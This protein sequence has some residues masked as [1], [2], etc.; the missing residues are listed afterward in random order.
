VFAP[1]ISTADDATQLRLYEYRAV[2]LVNPGD[3]PAAFL[4]RLTGYVASGGGV[5]IALGDRTQAAA[6]NAAMHSGGLGFCPLAL[7]EPQGNASD[8]EQFVL[9]SPPST[10]SRPT[11]LLGDTQRLD[12][13][14]VRLYR[15]FAFGRNLPSQSV[16]LLL[17]TEHG[18][19][20]AF[21]DFSGNGRVIWLG[22]P[23]DLSWSNLPLCKSF[24]ALVREWLWYLAEPAT[25]QRNLMPGMPIRIPLERVA[26]VP[27]RKADLASEEEAVSQE[28]TVELPGGESLAMYE[29]DPS[30]APGLIF[31]GTQEPGRYLVSESPG[32]S[33]PD[34]SAPSPFFVQRDA[35]ESNLEAITQAQRD[36][37]ANAGGLRYGSASWLELRAHRSHSVAQ[38]IASYLLFA[39]LLVLLAEL[40]LAAWSARMRFA[41]VPRVR[42][43]PAASVSWATFRVAADRARHILRHRR[44]RD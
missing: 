25:A 16:R 2:L 34:K 11:A 35:F 8:H 38:P 15:R 5:W 31:R 22:V 4:Q 33:D 6:F 24:V 27:G 41:G 17:E 20:L 14:E 30:P 7:E 37:L 39:L 43:E 40:L 18:A 1:T 23:L 3:V 36:F 9:V 13:N 21:E 19:T 10:D 32:D 42:T 44:L 12:I 26:D 28:A 29:F